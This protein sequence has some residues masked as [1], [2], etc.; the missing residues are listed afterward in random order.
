[1]RKTVQNSPKSLQEPSQIPAD[2][3]IVAIGASAGGLEAL[4]AFFES[5]PEET[6]AAF[7]VIQHL[8]PDYKS[9]MGELLKRSTSLPIVEVSNGLAVKPGH[10]YLIPPVNNL[11]LKTGL[12]Y[13]SE[14]P[15]DQT[16]N[17]PIDIFFES[18]AREKKEKA[19]GVILSGT[20]SDGTRGARAIKENDG[21]I[22]VQEPEEAQ[23]DGMPKSAINTGLVDYVL[24]VDGM[25]GELNN[26][27]TAPSVFHFDD[28][29]VQ[30]DQTELMKI[31]SYVDQK[32]GL[33][34]REY[35]RS[36]LAR[37]VARRVNVCK[38]RSLADYY[39]HLC[40]REGE[41]EILYREFLI[42]VTKFFRDSKVWE[43]LR[44]KVFPEMVKNTN[45]GETLKVWNVACSTGEEAYSFAI[46]LY[47]EI[48]KQN[49]SIELKIFATDISNKHLEIGSKGKYPESIA[50][51]VPAD[52]LSKYFLPKPH[53]Y[54]VVEKLRRA[55]IFSCHNVIKNPPFSN[56]DLVSCRNL[57]IY[58][59]PAIQKKALNVLHYAL[60]QDGILV[61]GTSE[62]MHNQQENFTEIDRK[63][64]IYQ[65]AHPATRLN[66][67]I[68]HASSAKLIENN[69][70]RQ[71]KTSRIQPQ[72]NNS[73][74]NLD[75]TNTLLEHF[76][77]ASVFIDSEY[78][79]LEAIGEFRK[80]AN[81]PVNGFSIN[82][83]DMLEADL[84]YLVQNTLKK[85]GKLQKK[86][87]YQDAVYTHDGEKKGVDIVVKPF[88][89][90]NQ[91][92]DAYF[93]VNFIE[94]ELNLE[95]TET[96]D[97]ITLTKRTKEYVSNLEEELKQ[98]KEELQ[99]SLEEIETSNE[100]LQAANEELLA[101]NEE[102]QST[103]EELQSVNEEI[104]TV[105]AENLQKM[106]DLAALNADMN[107]LLKSTQIGTIFLDANLRIR[108]F[109]P[110][111]KEHFSFLNSDIGRPI[112]HFTGNIGRSNLLERCKR[113]LSSGK[114]L[115]K[116]VV[117]KDGVHY[118]RRIS[119][120]VGSGQKV[121]GVVITFIDIQNLQKS[122]EKLEASEK[123]FKSFY[124]ED[125]VIHISVDPQTSKIIHCNKMAV[126][127]LQYKSLDELIGLPIYDLYSE[128][129]QIK[130][131]KSNKEF[132]KKGEL[133]NVEQTIISAKEERIPV[134]MNALAETD[135]NDKIVAVRYTFVDISDVKKAENQLMQQKADLERANKDLEQFVSICSHDLQEPLSTIKFGSDVLGKMYS[136]KLDEKGQNYISY[137]KNAS[138]RL[139]QQ[140]KALLEHSR[141]GR[142]GQKC[143]VDTKEVVEVVKY[144]LG[145]R[146]KD[147]NAKVH[148]GNLPKID[149]Y[150][151][152]LRLLFQ[153]LISNAIKYTP[154]ERNPEVRISAYKENGY[155]VFSVVD[156]GKGIAKENLQKVF[157][158]FN[159]V[160]GEEDEEGTGVGLA[161]VEK[162][163]NLHDG[164]I[165]V[166][167][168]EGVGSS[169]YFKIKA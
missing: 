154:K 10:I 19:V 46:C 3:R 70:S 89:Q 134:I 114:T 47:E 36:T 83:L 144:D 137:I 126:K 12:L 27:I 42:G 59:Q 23:F 87:Y 78:N 160:D 165:W 107:N 162:I 158:I 69:I 118:L 43:Q 142:N 65:N 122:K 82:L 18:L 105:N 110:A 13:L 37:R 21:M 145:K 113:V 67:E 88:D 6:P 100:E 166:D 140:I 90:Q 63:W 120:Y 25:G 8:S 75:F 74:L 7:V 112:S 167:S 79:I 128:E 146:I 20:G 44:K 96:V 150:E 56:M 45:N 119:P 152:E 148:S 16:L 106:D 73:R 41:V 62:S 159:R 138:T 123:R 61:L 84:K 24:P 4:K 131:L 64:K 132:Y 147:T 102:L 5:V 168:Q 161:H 48:E 30:Y 34:F 1:M 17:L 58:F 141:I 55:V 125:P 169:F 133:V 26:F 109:T 91:E 60:K 143:V 35:K 130:A 93:V 51:D 157:T 116:P 129:S 97:N 54:R 139:S 57:L 98:T 49:K 164:S 33:D 9:M 163:V 38:C 92:G 32:T 103:N 80:Y 95:N 2:T 28:G 135:E 76:N 31:L 39:T 149:G 111:I 52:L 53:S 22:M 40:S 81:L 153:N 101:S 108:K 104:N 50:A 77:A 66:S 86:V 68:S 151:V 127:R 155:W 14:K 117:S 72:T 136:D 71:K 156:N 124:E 29:D 99:T 85:A 11:V 94:K 115:E 15:K 121:N